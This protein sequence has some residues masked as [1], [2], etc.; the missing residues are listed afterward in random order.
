MQAHELNHIISALE[1]MDMKLGGKNAK[2]KKKG[3]DEFMNIKTQ[4]QK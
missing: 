4:I 3:N 1:D 2:A